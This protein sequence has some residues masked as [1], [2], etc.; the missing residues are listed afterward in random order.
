MSDKLELIIN[1]DV[2]MSA[3]ELVEEL[4][5]KIRAR[6]EKGRITYGTNTYPAGRDTV[7]DIEEEL[8]D[9]IV[10]LYVLRKKIQSGRIQK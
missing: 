3:D 6:L 2:P 7:Q 10:Y 1:G 5:F 4:N 9:A 8:L